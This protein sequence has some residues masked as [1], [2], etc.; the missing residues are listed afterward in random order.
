MKTFFF[1]AA[2]GIALIV[3]GMFFDS[4]IKDFSNEMLDGCEVLEE[5]I[6][7]GDASA[8][9]TDIETFL[10][11]KKTLL[12]S[13]INHENIDEIEACITEIKGYVESGDMNEATVRCEKLKLLVARLP[14][15]YGLS[16]QNIL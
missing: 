13:I 7:V 3:G 8:T 14:M 10:N 16:L 11:R 1:A 12:A 15:E 4:C 2:I 6:K 5:K 9:A